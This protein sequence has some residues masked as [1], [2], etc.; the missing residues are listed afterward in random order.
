MARK[1]KWLKIPGI[2]SFQLM[3]QD[4]TVRRQMTVIVMTITTLGLLLSESLLVYN[5]YR[6]ARTAYADGLMT[7]AATLAVDAG[8]AVAANDRP[9]AVVTLAALRDLRQI[10]RAAIYHIDESPFFALHYYIDEPNHAL[11]PRYRGGVHFD[12]DGLYVSATIRVSQRNYGWVVLH[13]TYEELDDTLAGT[14]AVALLVMGLTLLLCWEIS[15]QLQRIIT[16]PIRNLVSL[17]ISIREKNDFTLR[18]PIAGAAELSMLALAFNSMLDEIELRDNRLLRQNEELELTIADRT[19]ALAESEARFKNLADAAFEGILIHNDGLIIDANLMAAAMHGYSIDEVI[20]KSFFDLL[21]PDAAAVAREHYQRLSVH[22]Y[23]VYSLRKDGARFPLEIRGKVSEY[24][25]DRVRVVAMRDITERKQTEAALLAAKEAAEESNRLKSEFVANMSHEIRTPLNGVIGM[26]HLLSATPLA[27]VQRDYAQTVA[28]SA[29]ALLSIV[30]DILDFSKIE[31]GKMDLEEDTL[32]M[33]DVVWHA[34]QTIRARA[35]EKG[36]T[37]HIRTPVNGEGWVRGDAMRL[38]QILT[39]LAAN[40]VKFTETGH[41]LLDVRAWPLDHDETDVIIRVVDTGI[42]V[43]ADR[44]VDI[45]GKFTQADAS[46]TRLF[47]G[48]GLGLAITKEL[49]EMMGGR[50]GVESEVGVGSVFTCRLTMP[51]AV[52]LSPADRFPG[53]LKGKRVLV[54][55]T[56]ELGADIMRERVVAHGLTC[57]VASTAEAAVAAVSRGRDENRPYDLAILSVG[58]DEPPVAAL[59]ERLRRAAGGRELAFLVTSFGEPVYA[60]E[61]NNGIGLAQYLG[62]PATPERLAEAL[63]E[64]LR[65]DVFAAVAETDREPATASPVRLLVVEDNPV[66]QKVALYL[67]RSFGAE[68]IIA[69]NGEEAVAVVGAGRYD[70]VLMDCS[71]PVMDGFQATKIIRE[72][73]GEGER[74]PIIAMTAHALS[75]DRERC[76]AAGMDEYLTKPI[77]RQAV[78]TMLN[79]FVGGRLTEKAPMARPGRPTPATAARLPEDL[80]GLNRDRVAEASM[81]DDDIRREIVAT[82]L[83]T[84]PEQVERLVVALAGEEKE[85]VE[86]TAHTVKGAA[87]NI[88]A[89]RL[90]EVA[91]RVELAAREGR[92]DLCRGEMERL[93][94]ELAV[95]VAELEKLQSPP[96]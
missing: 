83:R 47:G 6:N 54:V 86:R 4:T 32:D 72:N 41:I 43:P 82:A 79:R 90:G 93:R 36:L 33:T 71:M 64:G 20:G 67:L 25:G 1:I 40:A 35:R 10:R 28:D 8:E 69:E 15:L 30:N 29:A 37:L 5:H 48:A 14:T 34:A 62:R 96:A 45:F 63:V 81:G 57:D 17:T 75:G 53:P 27:P 94:A 23:E 3:L 42:G 66:N 22:P 85:G 76:L 68:V 12:E 18:A 56:D 31:A 58:P 55:E 9:S 13:S 84:I 70:A 44:L 24:H 16:T 89:E 92:F 49:V 11:P 26:A 78:F 61:E 88:G 91:S 50:I 38:R 21:P 52:G 39:N 80:R 59:G 2:P 51:T 60:A 19:A 73:E 77:D 65:G 7:L 74:T 95:A 87:R 46:T